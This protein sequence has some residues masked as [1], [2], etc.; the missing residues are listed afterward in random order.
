MFG[1]VDPHGGEADLTIVVVEH[2]SLA[3]VL[4]L[5]FTSV[6]ESG[7]TLEEARERVAGTGGSR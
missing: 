2:P 7:L 3:G 1:M 5:A 6:W 4:R